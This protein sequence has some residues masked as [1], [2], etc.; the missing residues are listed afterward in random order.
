MRDYAEDLFSQFRA[1]HALWIKTSS[2][3]KLQGELD[4]DLSTAD[5]ARES[6]P[7]PSRCNIETKGL[8]ELK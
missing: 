5:T 1:K 4:S 3:T 7:L 8:F 6:D 2:E